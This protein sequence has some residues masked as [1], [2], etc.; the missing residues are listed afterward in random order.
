MIK[1]FNDLKNFKTGAITNGFGVFWYL[2]NC[3]I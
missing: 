3:D 2:I 1:F